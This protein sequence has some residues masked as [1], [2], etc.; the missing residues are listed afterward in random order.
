[1]I[2]LRSED[3]VI[4]GHGVSEIVAEAA[5][6]CDWVRIRVEIDQAHSQSLRVL[7]GLRRHLDTLEDKTKI[8]AH[9]RKTANQGLIEVANQTAPQ[10]SFHDPEPSALPGGKKL[11]GVDVRHRTTE[12]TQGAKARGGIRSVPVLPN[13][14]D[15]R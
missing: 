3:A 10:R 2:S 11:S 9:G 15:A 6:V 7:Q 12:R 4:E 1:M 14:Q 13:E 8:R 5:I